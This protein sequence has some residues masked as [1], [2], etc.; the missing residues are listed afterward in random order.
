MRNLN[1]KIDLYPLS[2]VP[3]FKSKIWGGNKLKS[4]LNKDIPPG[5]IG[6]SWEISSLENNISIVEK[7]ELEGLS[8]VDVLRLYG[9]DLVGTKSYLLFGDK[10]PLLI[11]YIDAHQDL[12][13]QV[14]PNNNEALKYNSFGKTEMWYVC[15][16]DVNA[17]L[18]AG[19]KQESSKEELLNALENNNIEQILNQEIVQAEDAF[20][21]PAHSIHSIGKGVLLAEIQQASDLT[22]R[23]YDY[24]RTDSNGKKRD[25]HVSEAIK[26]IDYSEHSCRII[27]NDELMVE[28]E[29]FT[30]KQIIINGNLNKCLRHIDSFVIYM[31][32]AGEIEIIYKE[33]IFFIRR[34]ETIL[35]PACIDMI[36]INSDT[37]AKVLEIYI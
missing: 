17:S 2:F 21:I 27:K 24:N 4:F 28:C 18:I 15:Q 37:Y 7:G 30:T 22:F 3:I 11:K 14:H 23:L 1:Y 35:I 26:M 5:N 12:S 32:V 9:N 8:I 25:L 20:L 34:G 16:A 33:E 19:F 13:I 6:E 31:C 29:F 36:N 10:F